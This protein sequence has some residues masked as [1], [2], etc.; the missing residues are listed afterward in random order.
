MSKYTIELRNLVENSN[1]DLG[2][3]DYPLYVF[4]NNIPEMGKNLKGQDITE[5]RDYLNNYIYEHF[6]FREIGFETPQRFVFM[7]NRKMNEIMTYYN[8]MFN[9]IDI[10]FN[11]LWNVD[12]TETYTHNITD[13]GK[14]DST[15][16]G[17]EI[18]DSETNGTEKSTRT[19][20][21]EQNINNNSSNSNV[22]TPNTSTDT[23]TA[24]MNTAQSNLSA[25]QIRQHEYISKA[26]H[27]IT[28][29]TGTET[30]NG[31]SEETGKT[32]NDNTIKNSNDSNVNTNQTNTNS[33][34]TTI[35]NTNSRTETYT[36]HEEG[37]SAGYLFT[38]NI[39]QWRKIMINIPSMICEELEELFMQ[40]F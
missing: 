29:N 26:S 33:S 2:M 25:D 27:I 22:K 38:Q 12:L 13:T 21:L 19:E 32:T 14:T 37:S 34:D 36:R 28:Q 10:K 23:V 20:E 15:S 9:S 40:I 17:K 1:V 16:I 8:Q 24:D 35:N 18:I 5:F 39:E 3:K 7:M 31:T 4:K 30:D 6:Y 11:P